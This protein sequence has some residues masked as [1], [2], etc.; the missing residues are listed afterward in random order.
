[1]AHGAQ[2]IKAKRRQQA[3]R[4]FF[5]CDVHGAGGR[6][7]GSVVHQPPAAA[8]RRVLF[9]QIVGQTGV[10]DGDAVAQH[11]G[12]G[13]AGENVT[14][15]LAQLGGVYLRQGHGARRH[16]AAGHGHGHI[17]DVVPE[18]VSAHHAD[19]AAHQKAHQ[20]RRER[21]RQ[22]A[23]RALQQQVPVNAEQAAGDQGRNVQHQKALVV[24]KGV[25]GVHGTLGEHP[26]RRQ[27]GPAE[28]ADHRAAQI[29]F[30]DGNGVA[31]IIQAVAQNHQQE[32]GPHNVPGQAVHPKR[33]RQ[34]HQRQQIEPK[35]K[36]AHM[37]VAH[38]AFD[39]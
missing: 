29:G 18:A 30:Y 3:H 27:N 35:G 26:G 32:E 14:G 9:A 22:N 7:G 10:D 2:A 37:D 25:H 1:M 16:A 31:Q 24:H 12:R 4:H 33:R 13:N 19:A 36:P 23:H 20:Q 34:Q 17:E 39:R 15:V 8:E 5:Q 11:R 21:H 28:D 38:A 6:G